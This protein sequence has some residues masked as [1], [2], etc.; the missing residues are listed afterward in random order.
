MLEDRILPG[1]IV[2]FDEVRRR[3][4]LMAFNRPH[5]IPLIGRSLTSIGRVRSW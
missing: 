2:V 3:T 5:S 4:W 1:A